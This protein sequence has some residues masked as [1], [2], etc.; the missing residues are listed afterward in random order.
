[1]QSASVLLKLLHELFAVKDFVD[2]SAWDIPEVKWKDVLAQQVFPSDV[3][4]II[5]VMPQCIPFEVRALLFRQIV[6]G[7]RE[8][9]QHQPKTHVRVRRT[10]LFQDGFAAF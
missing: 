10:Q 2:P 8:R 1:M 7:D 6:Q 4:K 5:H 3:K 9:M